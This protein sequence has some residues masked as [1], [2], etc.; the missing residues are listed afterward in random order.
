MKGRGLQDQQLSDN[1]NNR[2]LKTSVYIEVY[3]YMYI[4][5]P[6][7]SISAMFFSN[8]NPRNLLHK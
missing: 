4:V 7:P 6:K 1:H 5:A 8:E 3:N 2:Y